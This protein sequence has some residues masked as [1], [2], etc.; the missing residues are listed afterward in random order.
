MQPDCTCTDQ[1]DV[2]RLAHAGMQAAGKHCMLCCFA[3]DVL[4][5]PAA[6]TGR[7]ICSSLMLQQ[8]LYYNL[9]WSAA[10]IIAVGVRVHIKVRRQAALQHT[11]CSVV[12]AGAAGSCFRS[13]CNCWCMLECCTDRLCCRRYQPP[14]AAAAAAS[15]LIVAV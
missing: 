13:C 1:Q 3:T 9:F 12:K 14:T 6:A 8:L 15:L 2:A 4:Q 11:M 7:E 10:W 5:T